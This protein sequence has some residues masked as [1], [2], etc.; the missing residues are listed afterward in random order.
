VSEISDH[1]D[2]TCWHDNHVHGF[3]ILE[4]EHGTGQFVLDIDHILKW[5]KIGNSFRFVVAPATLTFHEVSDLRLCLD[6]ATP[7]AGITP[8]SIDTVERQPKAFPNGYRT[9]TWRVSFAW[10]HGEATFQSSG[11]SLVQWGEPSEGLGQWLQPEER[12]PRAGP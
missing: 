10:P 5:I 6:Y 7:T 12:I 9:F 4:G 3:R 11:F 2:P 1:F 8:P